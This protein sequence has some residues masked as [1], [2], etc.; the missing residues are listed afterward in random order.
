MVQKFKI[1]QTQRAHQTQ[2]HPD[3]VD[4]PIQKVEIQ[5]EKNTDQTQ[6]DTVR[7]G[8]RFFVFMLLV[9]AVDFS[10]T[11]TT[12]IDK[13]RD[14]LAPS[15]PKSKYCARLSEWDFQSASLYSAYRK[16]PHFFRES[17]PAYD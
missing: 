3:I 12:Y 17:L 9:S 6:D 16:F 5:I 8:H 14:L 7:D 2:K 11:H 13:F 10:N 15:T 4:I 1:T